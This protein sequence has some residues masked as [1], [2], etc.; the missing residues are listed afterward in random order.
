MNSRVPGFTNHDSYQSAAPDSRLRDPG[1]KNLR[2]EN[3]KRAI[4]VSE[5]HM[6]DIPF[7]FHFDR[8]FFKTL[9]LVSVSWAS[10]E[11]RVAPL[12]RE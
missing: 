9:F 4:D 5:D 12:N 2:E 1:G 8:L 3:L 7:L 6:D 11:L 10:E